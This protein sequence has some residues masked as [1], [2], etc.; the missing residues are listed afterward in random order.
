MREAH[1]RGRLLTSWWLE[2]LK[3]GGE[4]GPGDKTHSSKECPPS[5]LLPDP[6]PTYYTFHHLPLAY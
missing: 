5:D 1:S 6:G 4:E 2:D 3:R